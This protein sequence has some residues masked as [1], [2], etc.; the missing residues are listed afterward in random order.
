MSEEKTL[1]QTNPKLYHHLENAKNWKCECGEVCNPA[2]AKW[3]WNGRDW[4]HQH[5]YPM[6]HVQAEKINVK[7]RYKLCPELVDGDH[8]TVVD[9]ISAVLAAVEEWCKCQGEYVGEQFEV[10]IV[11]MTEE[12]VRALPEI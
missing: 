10:E 6:G 7:P 2:S 12:E 5:G 3:R 1:E 8:W 4:E 11:G 9:D